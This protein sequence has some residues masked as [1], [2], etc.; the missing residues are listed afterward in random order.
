MEVEWQ[1][2]MMGA[3]SEVLETMFFEFVDFG[4]FPADS[5][6]KYL[7]TAID[8]R[9]ADRMLRITILVTEPFSRSLTSNFLSK[10]TG[11]VTAD[12]L[13]D[14]MK[15]LANMIGGSFLAGTGKDD[16]L[17]QIP[18]FISHKSSAANAPGALQ[19]SSMG[20]HVGSVFIHTTQNPDDAGLDEVRK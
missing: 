17:L 16:W 1:A 11:T 18:A 6:T 7:E 20:T 15:E 19:L 4:A 2:P 12:E 13:E 14:M 5:E 9:T 10:D 8:V 3:I